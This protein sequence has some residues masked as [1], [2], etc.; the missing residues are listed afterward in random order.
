MLFNN[1]YDHHP[2]LYTELEIISSIPT[3]K[4]FLNK[5]AS[6]TYN[7]R[8]ADFSKLYELIGDF[9][10]EYLKCFSDINEACDYFY[11]ALYTIFDQCVPKKIPKRISIHCGLH[12]KLF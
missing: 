3:N 6:Y 4:T 5:T 10:W 11:N 9:D 12:V 8:K 7:F 2:A 1:E